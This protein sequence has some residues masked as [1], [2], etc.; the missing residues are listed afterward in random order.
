MGARAD[1]LQRPLLVAG[2]CPAGRLA[3][4]VGQSPLSAELTEVHGLDFS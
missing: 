2:L 3:E 1:R 4:E